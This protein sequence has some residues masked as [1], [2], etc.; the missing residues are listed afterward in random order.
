MNSRFLRSCGIVALAGL[1]AAFASACTCSGTKSGQETASLMKTAQTSDDATPPSNVKPVV[2]ETGS[3]LNAKSPIGSNLAGIADWATELPFIDIFK[4]SRDWISCKEGVWGDDRKLDLDANGWIRS[5]QPGQCARALALW[6]TN[7]FPAG[8]YTVLYEGDG[9]I[10]YDE[11]ASNRFVAAESVPGRHIVDIDPKRGNQGLLLT[12][13]RTNPDNPIRNIRVLM[14]GGVCTEEMTRWCDAS[15]GCGEAGSCEPFDKNYDKVIFNPYFIKEVQRYSVIRFMDWMATNDSKVSK[16]SERPRLEDARWSTHGVPLEVMVELANRI[17][18][19][20]WFNMPHLADDDYITRFATQVHK[21]LDAKSRV[22][23]E[24]SNEVWNGI[25][26]QNP[27]VARCESGKGEDGDYNKS[28]LCYAER[29]LEVF[30][31]W[32]SA[33]LDNPGRVVRVLGSQSESAWATKRILGHRDAYKHAD[34]VAIAPYFGQTARPENTDELVGMNVDA[35]VKQ[36]K[37]QTLPKTIADIKEQAGL[38]AEHQLPLVA[39]E[40]GPAFDATFG[41]ENNDRINALFDAINRDPRLAAMY[42]ELLN[43]W[44]GAG[45]QLFVNY[46]S[47]DPFSKWGR[48]GLLEYVTQPREDAPKYDAIQTYIESTPRWW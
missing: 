26:Q 19:E 43:A 15:N 27:D 48:F 23:V 16:W 38:A 25:F 21:S 36:V 35:L 24:F 39:Y 4:T 18:V 31:L 29:S 37:E 41:A 11:G 10:V 5:L 28:H 45:A 20:P 33:F 22:W 30:A 14:P 13:T 17:K 7:R 42:I 40:G 3:A 34:A 8:N 46:T 44:K 32:R 2:W 12:I 6:D 1:C 9:D 47:C